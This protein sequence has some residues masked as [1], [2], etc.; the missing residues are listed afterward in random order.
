[1]P[2][3]TVAPSGSALGVRALHVALPPVSAAPTIPALRG[4]NHIFGRATPYTNTLPVTTNLADCIILG[5][6][7]DGAT[8]APVGSGAGATWTTYATGDHK[9]SLV[10]GYNCS[11]GQTTCTVT[12]PGATG[13][14]NQ[15]INIDCSVWSGIRSASNPVVGSPDIT[16]AGTVNTITS[17]SVSYSTNQLVI[18]SATIT[19]V[20]VGLA[21]TW[22]NTGGATPRETNTS[23]AQYLQVPYFIAISSNSTTL[24]ENSGG[25]GIM[26]IIL[27]ILQNAP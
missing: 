2:L 14:G 19:N 18:A 4:A 9:F 16:E 26:A 21:P 20:S 7:T 25:T 12:A 13:S 24:T 17:G 8:S 27:A 23:G 22:S 11:A 3:A 10:V 1:V 6:W 5:L 15:G